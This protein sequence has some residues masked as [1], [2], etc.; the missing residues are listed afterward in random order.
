MMVM[1]MTVFAPDPAHVMVMRRLRRAGI[2]LVADDLGAVF[3]ELAIHR[4][5]HFAGLADAI[6]KRADHIGMVA[7]I[8]RLDKFGFG[9]E[10]SDRLGLLVNAFDQDA[11]KQ[12]IWKHDNTAKA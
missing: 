6:A 7:Q 3:A 8:E 12:E 5:L 4:R 2:A 10:T 9:K 11:G 1:R